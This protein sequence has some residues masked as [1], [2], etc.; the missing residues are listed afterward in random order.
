MIAN[1]FNQR[2]PPSLR[3]RHDEFEGV[4]ADAPFAQQ[5]NR[6][7]GKTIV[8]VTHDQKAADYASR[9]LHV[10]K[11]QIVPELGVAA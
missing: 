3:R 6:G 4:T 11:G 10:D 5:L 7:Q 1:L 9:Q 2:V 8:M